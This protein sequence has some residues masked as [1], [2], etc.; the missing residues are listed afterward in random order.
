MVVVW[1]RMFGVSFCFN[2]MCQCR[3]CIN[4]WVL[5]R[6]V[7]VTIIAML[8]PSCVLALPVGCVVPC[9]PFCDMA[10]THFISQPRECPLGRFTGEE[11]PTART[12]EV[13]LGYNNLHKLIVILDNSWSWKLRPLHPLTFL[14]RRHRLFFPS[15]PFFL[16][17]FPSFY[18][19]LVVSLQLHSVWNN[20]PRLSFAYF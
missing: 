6:F 8:H 11:Q 9:R 14:F 17:T 16:I 2:C 15:H 3:R 10:Q 19:V 18:S 4:V 5:C 20:F 13:C 7:F 1:D 12:K